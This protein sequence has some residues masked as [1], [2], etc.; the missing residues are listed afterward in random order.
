MTGVRQSESDQIPPAWITGPVTV[1][2]TAA[3]TFGIIEPDACAKRDRC[4]GRSWDVLRV[5]LTL[6]LT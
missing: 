5:T 6:I 3:T 2:Q 4:V 1:A